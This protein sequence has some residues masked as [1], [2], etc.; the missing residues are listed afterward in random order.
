MPDVWKCPLCG[1]DASPRSLRVDDFLVAVRESLERRGELNVKA[2]LVTE[3]G[4]WTVKPE[5]PAGRRKSRGG[6]A[7]SV[8]RDD[9]GG[10]YNSPPVQS[11]QG[12]RVVEVIEVDGD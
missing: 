6:W 4:E 10:D 3:D 7:G 12:S 8:P 11:R 1:G 9:S 5:A 2:V